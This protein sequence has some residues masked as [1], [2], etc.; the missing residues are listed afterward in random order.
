MSGGGGYSA[1]KQISIIRASPAD[2]STAPNAAWT[3]VE[4]IKA[5]ACD[6]IAQ[7]VRMMLMENQVRKWRGQMAVETYMTP[8]TTL[9]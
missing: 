5:W 1:T 4:S 9:R 8:G 2:M 6:D 3:F 7:P